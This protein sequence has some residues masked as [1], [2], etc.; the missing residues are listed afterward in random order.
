MA[1]FRVG[2]GGDARI[3]LPFPVATF[4]VPLQFDSAVALIIEILPT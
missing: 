3:D 1:P 4:T 2:K